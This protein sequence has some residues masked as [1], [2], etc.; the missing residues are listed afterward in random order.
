MKG[1][2]CS[3]VV[4]LVSIAACG[5]LFQ[6]S[7]VRAA[8]N[9][10]LA[11]GDCVKCHEAPPAD[12][13][14]A[15][16]KH[17][18]EVSCV[19]C[20]AGHRPSSKN[21]I[22][23]C[24]Q[25]HEGKPHYGLKNCLECHKNPHKPL[26]I[27]IAAKTTE[28]CLT[29][30]TDQIKQLKE[31]PSKHSSQYCSACHDVHRKVPDCVKCHRPHSP[32]MAQADCKKCHKAHKPKVVVYAADVPNNACGACHK[33]A[34]AALS[35]STAKHRNLAC[36]KCHENK[37]KTVPACELCHGSK[38]PES[39]MKKFP[40]CGTCHNIAHDLNHWPEGG[41]VEKVKTPPAPVKA[42]KK[43]RR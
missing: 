14:A 1:S 20:H 15:G 34:L 40:R 41:K 26:D 11:P 37:H 28:P 24:S 3:W 38:H 42:E 22:P 9:V 35:A 27:V 6:S 33:K 30:H 25:C 43:R 4:A 31:N 5:L 23:K 2:R 19:D 12:V 36:V 29:C 32:E 8:D 18:T 10:A 16:A 21:N 13:A 39:I 7:P 17:K